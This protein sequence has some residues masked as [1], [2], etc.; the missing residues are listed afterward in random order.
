MDEQSEYPTECLNQST[1][2]IYAPAIHAAPRWPKAGPATYQTAS[3]QYS[4][5]V[6]RRMAK[7]P[8]P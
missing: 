2:F 4:R 6:S 7:T 1:S 8:A 3:W 5:P